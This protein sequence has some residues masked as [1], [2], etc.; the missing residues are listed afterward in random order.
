MHDNIKPLFLCRRK[1][2][3]KKTRILLIILIASINLLQAQ[4]TDQTQSKVLLASSFYRNNDFAK[5]APLYLELFESSNSSYYFENY[6]NC[7]IGMKDFEEAEKALKKQLKKKKESIY[8]IMLGYIAKEKGDVEKA[9][10]I[11][12][13]VLK[14]M[15]S[16]MGLIVSTANNF[17]N[18][19]EYEYAEK[20]YLRGR[21]L[22]PGEFFRSNLATIYA[23]SRNYSRMMEEYLLLIK[24]D[25][26]QL[27]SVQGRLNS[28]IRY[29]FDKTL[30]TTVKKEVLKKINE[31][32]NTLIYNRLLI[33]F[34]IQEENYDLALSHSISL[35]KRT[36]SEEGAILDFSY[37]ATQNELYDIALRGLNYLETRTPVVSNLPEVKR[38]LVSV[39]YRKFIS[40]PENQRISAEK[41]VAKFDRLLEEQGFTAQNS[42]FI[43][44]YAH[45]LAFYLNQIPK[46]FEILERA[47][48]LPDLGN[49]QRS[50]LKLEL[51]D[52]NVYD[53][54]LWTATLLYAQIIDSNKDN[55]IGD[56]AKLKKAKLGFY[57]GDINWAKAQ[58]D[59][60]KASTSKLIANDA[61]ELS[62]L[63]TS[64]YELDTVELP[65]QIFARGDLLVLRNKD[66][67]AVETYDSITNL[68]PGHSLQDKILMR[69]AQISE[70]NFRFEEAV[71]FY[72]QLLANFASSTSADDALYNMAVIMEEKLG[73]KE[74]ASELFKQMLTTYP[75]SIFTADS[76][77][78]YRKFRGDLPEEEDPAT[79]AEKERMLN[80]TFRPE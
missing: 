34:F 11:Y 19:R 17:F 71:V 9:N 31:E 22:V 80:E 23:Y 75:S 48:E 18:R 1:I 2:V 53:N 10:S 16:N 52:L 13:D 37:A 45:F 44:D 69:K 55:P 61:M 51:A 29:D 20:A 79:E 54:S 59:V 49:L 33:W 41:L 30:S 35:D 77:Q 28:L 74:Q 39:E 38:Q 46:A 76:R 14:E 62:L 56:E 12:D 64:Y 5:A 50:A 26:K 42:A 72:K 6:V 36:R 8:T 15:P 7:L 67:E 24:E 21:E 68:F 25:E 43:L 3:M 65:I 70:K 47:V 27:Q 78:R 63:I 66:N 58:L 40:L 32:P 4:I 60:L 73:Q 57:L